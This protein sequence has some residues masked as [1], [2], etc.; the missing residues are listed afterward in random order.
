MFPQA[1]LLDT[2]RIINTFGEASMVP[3]WVAKELEPYHGSTTT[4]D[5]SAEVH[6]RGW[7][8]FKVFR[9]LGHL[10]VETEP[11]SLGSSSI[12]SPS[13]HYFRSPDQLQSRDWFPQK[14]GVLMS[15]FADHPSSYL[16]IPSLL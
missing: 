6:H 15:P 8:K 14:I 4:V 1:T 16:K 7:D 10:C 3:A 2:R 12:I 5:V 9:I 13:S 11:E